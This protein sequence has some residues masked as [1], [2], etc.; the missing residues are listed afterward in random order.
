MK[1]IPILLWCLI[2]MTCS[3]TQAMEQDRTLTL[4]Q[5]ITVRGQDIK[6][7]KT[8]NTYEIQAPTTMGR[9][10]FEGK[11]YL[12]FLNSP[13]WREISPEITIEISGFLYEAKSKVERLGSDAYAFD[14]LQRYFNGEDYK[15]FGSFYD[16]IK[17]RG[18]GIKVSYI[19]K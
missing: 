18:H 7:F 15:D 11:Y 9:W 6:V 4:L 13:L 5:K 8:G 1:K 14:W 16:F 19:C 17:H 2:S 10:D 12:S 3:I